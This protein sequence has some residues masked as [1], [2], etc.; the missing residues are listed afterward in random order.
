MQW[1]M[2][3][4][5]YKAAAL[6]GALMLLFAP[7]A[8]AISISDD[9]VYK[10]PVNVQPGDPT[11]V[12]L[13]AAPPGQPWIRLRP[14]D[15]ADTVEDFTSFVAGSANSTPGKNPKA[16]RAWTYD[17]TFEVTWD[18]TIDQG[19]P[20]GPI[21]DKLLFAILDS[22]FETGVPPGDT[23]DTTY[24]VMESGFLRGSAGGIFTVNNGTTTTTVTPELVRD[25][26]VGGAGEGF[27]KDHYPDLWLGFY[28]DALPGVTQTITMQWALGERLVKPNGKDVFFP[29]ALFA[30]VVPEPGAAALMGVG[31]LILGL[32]R[33]GR[34]PSA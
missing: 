6:L 7:G 5:G 17:I 11:P 34:R 14:N 26:T 29:N 9:Q 2:R 27:V 19:A 1:M 20:P 18:G 23:E 12:D 33:R 16:D 8:F 10:L 32:T 3:P 13:G 31:M 21:A 15:P 30:Q 24:K 25:D 28:I 22:R 4:V